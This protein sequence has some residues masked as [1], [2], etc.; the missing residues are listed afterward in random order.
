MKKTIFLC[1][2]LLFP[3]VLF[4]QQ[5]VIVTVTDANGGP[6]TG[7]TVLI[8]GTNTGGMTDDNGNLTISVN[9]GNTLVFSF[10]GY[11]TFEVPYTGQPAISAKLEVDFVGLDE[12]VVI[13]YGTTTKKEITGSVSTI[14]ADKLI[15]GNLRSPMGAIQGAV[16][17][18]SILKT[19][20]SDP[21]NEYTIRLRGL[22]SFS[23]GKSPLIL[24]DGVVWTQ[25]LDLLNP[26]LIES[27]D[28]LK[29]GSAA[30][31]YGTRATNGVILVSLKRP[32]IGKVRYEFSSSISLEKLKEDTRWYDAQG[33]RDLVNNVAPTRAYYLDRGSSTNWQDVVF[34]SPV[35]QN[36][37]F[38]VSGGAGKINYIANIYMKDD[39]GL[40]N[41]N[42]SRV[43]SPSIFVS[44]TG[45]N[46]RLYIDYTLMYSNA[47]RSYANTDAYSGVVSATIP[48]N[49]TE[50]IYDSTNIT[51]GGYYNK[52]TSSGTN[53]TYANP[54]AVINERSSEVTNNFVKGAFNASF[55]II[56]GLQAKFQ[57]SYNYYQS[58]SGTYSTK[59][60]PNLGRTGDASYSIYNNKNFTVEPSFEYKTT[61]KEHSLQA[62]AGYSYHENI[63]FSF[64]G[65][66]YNFDT[67]NFLWNNIGAG[68]ALGRGTSTLSSSK[69]SNKLIA[70]F[71]RAIY[72]YKSK[73][74]LSASLR[75]EGSSRFGVNNKWGLFPAVSIGW[76]LDQ[77][78]FIKNIS[79]INN[80]K[81]RGGYGVTGNQ[82]IPNYQS[83]IRMSV[84]AKFLNN[85]Q[86]INTFQSASN[87]NADLKWE[88]KTEYNLGIDFGIFKRISGTIDLYSRTTSDLLWYYTV[89]V[90]PNVLSY[91]YANVGSIRNRG[92]EIQLDVEPVK[93]SF[94][95]WTS[96]ISFTLNRN[97]ATKLSDPSR[98]YELPFL[99]LTPAATNWAQIIREGERVGNFWAPIYIGAK[100]DGSADYKDVDGNGTV[101]TESDREIV[102]HDYPDFE[103]GWRNSLKVKSFDLSFSFRGMFGQSLINYDR[104]SFENW[105]PFN[106]GA[107]VLKS[108]MDRPD[109]TSVAYVWDS[110][111]C[112]KSSFVKLDNIVVG[113]SFKIDTYN[114][115]VFA[116]GNN[117]LTWTTYTG[118]DPEIPIPD[119]NTS[120]ATMGWNNLTYPYSRV[121]TIGL[122][123]NF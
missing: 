113:Y 26:E 11:R 15:Q 70:F 79:W 63:D 97:M 33:Y 86:W 107:N 59:Y 51:G 60:F 2:L 91:L 61:I 28:V 44:Q 34:R 84:G 10:I 118:N 46:D 14:K 3:F 123:L 96:G 98:G 104:I 50:P 89:P 93:N 48:R 83:I 40:V 43:V 73:Y 29:D 18:L 9:Q 47:S 102:G 27:V 45:L 120:T 64:A 41:K 76:R 25:S 66:N 92:I 103:L 115:R 81:L 1:L 122:K 20:G 52:Y 37:S 101:S 49:P 119:F 58:N 121:Y 38:T 68:S 114:F 85:G 82:N 19:N 110:R 17:G 31:I 88:K 30:A 54:I 53:L 62:L 74:L 75:Y 78:S 117:L 108:I 22:S 35:D 65:G 90:P 109:Y 80:L 100:P 106:A 6:L 55:T 5:T 24:V 7:V 8:K 99:K 105:G 56:K 57:G 4:S 111:Y 95:T 116:S 94:I 36:H 112:E 87:P 16:A 12:I 42:F 72:N 71:G 21:N 32:E 39:Q 13:G 69:G 67:D 77:E 23:G